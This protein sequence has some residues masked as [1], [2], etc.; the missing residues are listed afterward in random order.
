MNDMRISI[1]RLTAL[2][3]LRRQLF[4]RFNPLLR[5]LHPTRLCPLIQFVPS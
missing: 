5:I 4:Q 3:G 2:D 1:F